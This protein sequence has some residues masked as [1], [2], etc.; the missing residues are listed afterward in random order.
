M[1]KK[2]TTEIH[3]LQKTLNNLQQKLNE[4]LDK[5]ETG[6]AEIKNKKEALR[7]GFHQRT[8]NENPED[9]P[10]RNVSPPSLIPECPAVM[11]R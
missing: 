7:V 5:Q 9:K 4:A 10:V 8:V 3:Y 11:K 1:D 6:L 2:S